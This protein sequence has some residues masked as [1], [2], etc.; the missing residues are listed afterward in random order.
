MSG[1][2]KLPGWFEDK[3]LASAGNQ[4][5]STNIETGVHKSW[6]MKLFMV[7]FNICGLSV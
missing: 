4:N 2:Q 3:E 6:A 1:P 7:V 5:Y